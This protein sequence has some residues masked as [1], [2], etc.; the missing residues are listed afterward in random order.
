MQFGN[1]YLVHQFLSPISN[2]RTDSYGGSLP[3]RMRLSLEIATLVRQSVPQSVVLGVR[4]SVSDFVT[5]GWDIPQTVELAKE[6]KKIGVDF[7]TCTSG[8]LV[9]S[10]LSNGM[11]KYAVQVPSAGLIHELTGIMTAA[12]GRIISPK[13]AEKIVTLNTASLVMIGRAMLN[14]PHW[15]YVAAD[16]LDARPFVQ[17]P[18]QYG[19]V[20]GDNQ[21]R[22]MLMESLK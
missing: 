20:I 9:P 12:V 6:L 4:V 16:Q 5:N 15:P 10:S 21:W 2:K 17:Y 11:D 18:K 19:Y 1:G 7:L 22:D 8:L 3:N 14:N 13:Y